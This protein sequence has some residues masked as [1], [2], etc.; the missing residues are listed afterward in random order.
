MTTNINTI[1][2]KNNKEVEHF[3]I[4]NNLDHLVLSKLK[5]LKIKLHITT[6]VN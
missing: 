6:M 1:L 2:K 3:I 5:I 4:E